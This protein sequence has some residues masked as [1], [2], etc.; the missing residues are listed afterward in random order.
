MS[1]SPQICWKEQSQKSYILVNI[2]IEGQ[3]NAIEVSN[4]TNPWKE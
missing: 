4:M 1:N 3:H 2:W